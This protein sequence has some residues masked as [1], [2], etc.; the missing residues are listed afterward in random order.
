MSSQCLS[1]RVTIFKKWRM[2]FVATRNAQNIKGQR[3]AQRAES[4]GS[5]TR[6]RQLILIESDGE[7]NPEKL[8]HTVARIA[9]IKGVSEEYVISETF[10]NA[11]RWLN[12]E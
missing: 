9:T 12:I 2:K 10:H 8:R 11:L 4:A 3:S 7:S 5:P 1:S 6:K